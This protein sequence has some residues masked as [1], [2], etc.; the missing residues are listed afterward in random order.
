MASGE[1]QQYDEQLVT[2]Y[3]LG[4]VPEAEAER[5]DELSFAD[6]EFANRLAAVENDLVDAY[7]HGEL[8]AEARDRFQSY[9]LSTSR[10]RE[11]LLQSA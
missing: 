4:S 2:R 5:L 1:H 3:L 7:V 9:Y 10:R 11:M 8:A 6:E